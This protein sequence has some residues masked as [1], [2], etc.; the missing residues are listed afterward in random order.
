MRPPTRKNPGAVN[1]GVNENTHIQQEIR[2]TT[3]SPTPD[4]TSNDAAV[5]DK[6]DRD[7][8]DFREY[9]RDERPNVAEG[10]PL[11]FLER[12]AMLSKSTYAN[13]DELAG[14][15]P[16]W[17]VDK[18]HFARSVWTEFLG[19]AVTLPLSRH[20][21]L[22]KGPTIRR[23]YAELQLV[24]NCGTVEPLIRLDRCA[25]VGEEIAAIEGAVYRLGLDEA[26]ELAHLL[27]LLVDVARENGS[28][29]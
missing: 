7:E 18:K 17:A 11:W 9:M 19:E 13:L 6:I 26:A 1:T 25:A 14:P 28:A 8:R 21:G 3:V 12:R 5:L 15:G 20:P 27:L 24:Q 23:A 4:T 10:S 22:R 2:M 29:A 16:V